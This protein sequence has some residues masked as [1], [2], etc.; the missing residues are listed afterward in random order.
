MGQG[1]ADRTTAVL[2]DNLRSG[3]RCR[4]ENYYKRKFTQHEHN[5]S[6]QWRSVSL[7]PRMI[8]GASGDAEVTTRSG[9]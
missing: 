6:K 4:K 9:S 3:C 1:S 5:P 8:A 7:G 2:A